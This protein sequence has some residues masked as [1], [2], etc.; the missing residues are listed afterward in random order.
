MKDPFVQVLQGLVVILFSSVLYRCDPGDSDSLTTVIRQRPPEQVAGTSVTV[1]LGY[2]YPKAIP[3]GSAITWDY[4][5]TGGTASGS[6]ITGSSTLSFHNLSPADYRLDVQ[7]K[8]N[9]DVGTRVSCEWRMVESVV[10][11]GEGLDPGFTVDGIAGGAAPTTD[12]AVRCLALQPDG[13]IL[14]GGD[15]STV[16]GS[17]R[18][19][20]ARLHPEG[21]VEAPETFAAGPFTN[22]GDVHAIAVQPDGKIIVAG[23]FV[24]WGGQTRRGIAR[25]EKNGELDEGFATGL[26]ANSS[27]DTM[28]LLPDGKL[29][30]AGPFT[31]FDGAPRTGLARLDSEGN[32]DP[33]FNLEVAGLI[34][35]LALQADGKVLL[36]GVFPE[37]GGHAK[38]SLA[39]LLTTGA[40]DTDFSPVIR[41]DGYYF[42]VCPQLDGR[43]LVAGSFQPP[44]SG[45]LR[46]S[47]NGQEET[48][49]DFLA[50]GVQ[51]VT[52]MTV[53]ADGRILIAGEFTSV[54]GQPRGGVARLLPDGTLE[55]GAILN[56]GAGATTVAPPGAGTVNAMAIQVDGKVLVGGNFGLFGGEEA[57]GVARLN[58]ER[59]VNELAP[60]GDRQ[61]AW[62]L[63]G[64]APSLHQVRFDLNTGNGWQDLGEGIATPTGWVLGDLASPLPRTGMLRGRGRNTNSGSNGS[65]VTIQ[66]PLDSGINSWRDAAFGD[67]AENPAVSGDAVDADGDGMANIMEYV[68]GMDPLDP[69]SR[70]RLE[71][72][73]DAEGIFVDYVRSD[74][75]PDAVVALEKTTHLGSWE[76]ASY[77]EEVVED[78]GDFSQMRARVDVDPGS[79]LQPRAFLRA[80]V[81]RA[82]PGPS[83]AVAHP[84][85]TNLASAVSD[86]DYR[87]LVVGQELTKTF[88]LKNRGDAPLQVSG[89]ALSGGDPGDFTLNHPPLPSEVVPGQLLEFTVRFA[90][91]SPGPRTTNIQVTSN[92]PDEGTF[93][94]S[95]TGHG[96]PFLAP[97]IEVELADGTP[98]DNGS[99]ELDFGVV[100][101]GTFT[102]PRTLTIRNV[103]NFPLTLTGLSTGGGE[104]SDFGYGELFLPF[105]VAPGGTETLFVTAQPQLGGTRTTTFE[106][107]SN[108]ADEG[109]FEVTLRVRGN[110]APQLQLPASPLLVPAISPA[111]ALVDFMV[112]ATDDD[113]VPAPNPVVNPASG[114][115]FPL[116]DTQVSVTA[117]DSGGL[118]TTGNFTVTVYPVAA[119]GSIAVSGVRVPGAPE[120]FTAFYEA[121]AINAQGTVGYLAYLA[122]GSTGIFH[123][124][125]GSASLIALSGGHAPGTPA[126][127]TYSY[128]AAGPRPLN[129]TGQ[130]TF[131]AAL[132][133]EGFDASADTGLWRGASGSVEL[134]VREGM[135]A[136]GTTAGTVF[137]DFSANPVL[138]AAGSCAFGSSLSGPDVDGTNYQ[139]L[140]SGTP[141]SLALLARLGSLAP[142]T[143]ETFLQLNAPRIGNSGQSIFSGQV[144]SGQSGLWTGAPGAVG[145]A[146]LSGTQAPGVPAGVH[147]SDFTDRSYGVPSPVID[148]Q[149]RIAFA[150]HLDT[151]LIPAESAA[152]IWAGPAGTLSLAAR[153][154]DPAP[155]TPAGQVFSDFGSPLINASGTVVFHAKMVDATAVP[156]GGGIWKRSSGI[157]SKVVATGD[158][159]PG[160]GV[161]AT[162]ASF[163]GATETVAFNDAGSVV[164][165]A[166]LAG[167]EV[168][169]ENDESLWHS[170]AG[171]VLTLI[172][173]EGDPWTPV[174]GDTRTIVSLRL[175]GSTTGGSAG[176]DGQSSGLGE[177][178]QIAFGASF[179]DGSTAIIREPSP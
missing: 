70:P 136:A 127:T 12:G 28:L 156:A 159:A 143:A 40:V 175:A 46:L 39:R 121:P 43:I 49:P 135:A 17:P 56:L 117:T 146:A 80:V 30:V 165:L 79:P 162:F 4:T 58:T 167:A 27:I 21:K 119:P 153:A 125:S 51:Q 93:T 45:L 129:A 29:L 37:V 148:A 124:S 142:G 48:A 26:G 33:G 73:S 50:T 94:F 174:V 168:T 18:H 149:D 61:V 91:D 66:L 102:P 128:F 154:G 71:A 172:V 115:L 31:A 55:S 164:F 151:S 157:L 54:S 150:A 87:T 120:P 63:A 68:L 96:A 34:T 74:L 99:G 9:G 89:I 35:G 169:S 106:I 62:T 77:T 69:L 131:A 6:G 100:N 145:L 139:G 11:T 138:N 98:L 126:G 140:W 19:R 116:G 60:R 16:N 161:G 2:D 144:S 97:E 75:A 123:G 22:S 179:A 32:L 166:V 109:A 114:T 83:I 176:Q 5:L 78:R 155:G 57:S 171:G 42:R 141:G 130:T 103:G 13:S 147:F 64:S 101:V 65:L 82:H 14:L 20:L 25:M 173:R 3:E 170:S 132:A 53:Q 67:D 158:G 134:L 41:P 95:L 107:V 152:G 85:D 10:P 111:G 122:G 160:A 52:N 177:N 1:T 44:T 105:D 86:V 47:Q 84:A 110:T 163:M 88:T 38:P 113:D 178:G 112:T 104:V 76:P 59:S 133:G 90:P 92:D 7:V 23:S 81:V 118:A 137:G 108:D 24:D 72:G 8:V 36:C 15:F